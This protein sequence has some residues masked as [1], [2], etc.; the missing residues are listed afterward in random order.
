MQ[1]IWAQNKLDFRLVETQGFNKSWVSDIA[2]DQY[3]FIW[4][5]TQDGLYR[6]DG[7]DML[8][9]RSH[10]YEATSLPGNWVRK[11]D[12]D[13]SGEVWI[14]TYGGGLSKFNKSSLVF[15]NFNKENPSYGTFLRWVKTTEDGNV[16]LVSD[17]GVYS[18]TASENKFL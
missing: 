12:I 18:Y 11:L 13:A 3:G 2:Q 6:Y 7:Y 1:F 14:A 8:S 16:F 9:F 10:P 4:L 17:L 5:G 15:Q